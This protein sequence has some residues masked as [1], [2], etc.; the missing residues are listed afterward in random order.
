MYKIDQ[1]F[2]SNFSVEERREKL[3]VALENMEPAELSTMLKRFLRRS[4]KSQWKENHTVATLWKPFH[5]ELGRL[6]SGALQRKLF[7]IIR[8]EVFK[9][10]N[11]EALDSSLKDLAGDWFVSGK[12]QASN[13]QRRPWCPLCIKSAW[14]KFSTKKFL[15]IRHGF[16]PFSTSE[17]EAVKT[18]VRWS[19]VIFSSKQQ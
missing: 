16:T 11:C 14:P 18:N 17:R 5:S 4:Q 1:P 15:Q 9:P 3:P 2:T 19:P 12:A 8:E 10:A 6:F 13:F 7:S